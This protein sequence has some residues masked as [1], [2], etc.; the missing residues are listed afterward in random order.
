MEVNRTLELASI[1]EIKI[2]SDVR[3]ISRRDLNFIH[4]TD[5]LHVQFSLSGELRGAITCYMC[6]DKQEIS[7]PDKNYIFP[8]FVEAMN[9]LI[10]KQLSHDAELKTFKL[11][12]SPPKLS[13][14]AKEI[15][16]AHK[17]GM[18]YYQLELDRYTFSILTEYSIEALS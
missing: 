2:L 18:Q 15:N 14:I 5:N 4:S 8:L 17:S 7:P 1:S 9:I 3:L 12:L 10:G 6:L 13:M 16:T 11:K